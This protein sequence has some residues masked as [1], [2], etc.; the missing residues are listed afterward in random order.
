M[1]DSDSDDLQLLCASTD[2]IEV[3]EYKIHLLSRRIDFVNTAI[4][5]LSKD[6]SKILERILYVETSLNTF[7]SW[8]DFRQWSNESDKKVDK[9]TY[10]DK[11]RLKWIILGV[12]LAIGLRYI[13]DLIV[14]LIGFFL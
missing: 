3:I 2:P 5:E 8:D 1:S 9:I 11:T 4:S 10:G 12:G 7:V 14:H 6:N 13:P